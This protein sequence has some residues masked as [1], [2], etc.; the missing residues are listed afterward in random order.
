VGAMGSV[1]NSVR[2]QKLQELVLGI[3]SASE[4]AIYRPLRKTLLSAN[5]P[6]L[7]VANRKTKTAQGSDIL[8]VLLK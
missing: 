6:I 3:T 1:F 8:S 2:W 4:Q 7:I 5:Q